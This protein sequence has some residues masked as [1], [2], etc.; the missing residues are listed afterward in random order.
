TDEMMGRQSMTPGYQAAAEW[1]AA[2]YEAWGLEPAGDNGT[3]FQRVPITRALTRYEGVPALGINGTAFSVI[4]GD[5]SINSVSTVATS[6]N[7]E[8]VFVGYGISAPAKGLDEYDG[9]NVRG[10][11]ALV[12]TGSPKDAPQS[13]GGG[14]MAPG[15][16][17]DPE[18]EEEWVEEST[19]PAKIQTAYD[20]GAAAVLLYNPDAA[21]QA[22]SG[23]RAPR[24][25]QGTLSPTRDFLAF[26]VTDR[27][28]RAIMKPDPQESVRGFTTRLNAVRNEI[29]YGTPQSVATGATA[30]LRGYASKEEYN[31]ELGNNFAYNVVAKLPGTDRGLRDEFVVMGGHLDHLGVR[32]GQVYNG[33]DD[34]A[35]GTAVAMEVA[36]VLSEGNH[37]PRRTIVFAAWCGEEMGLI[38]SGY[39]VSNPP[40]GIDI[41]KVVTYFNMDMVGL[42]NAIGA[43]GALNF[44]TIWDVIRRDQ[45]E[46]VIAAV[47][48]RTGGPGGSDHSA[49]IRLGIEALALMTSGGVGHPYYH[50]PEDDTEKIDAEILRKTGQFVLQGTINLAEER[51]VELLIEDRE[52]LYNAAQ[53]SLSSFNPGQG[54]YEKVQI[55]ARNR[56]ELVQ[57]VM[58][59]ALAVN[60]RLRQPAQ[61]AAQAGGRGGAATRGNKT[62][63]RGIGDLAVF[64]G[65]ANLLLSAAE[66]IGFGRLDIEGD[67]GSWFSGGHITRAGREAVG[68][69]EENNIWIHL[70]S[71]SESLFNE[72]L[73]LSS[74]PFIVTGEYTISASMVDA[75]NE[76]GVILGI[77]MDPS[78]VNGAITNL[79]GMKLRLGDTDNLVLSVTTEEGMDEAERALYMG[80]IE[81]GWEHLEIVGD[82]RA[83][84]GVAG[85]SLRVFST[86][87]AGMPMR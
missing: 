58:D 71:P 44:P 6:V 81:R 14:S 46:D 23:M 15:A 37:R 19:A 48:P 16:R 49:F 57:V 62:F 78:D 55:D 42:G 72:M 85:A 29:K 31:E 84:G 34:N 50:R 75:I 2:Q 20:K 53:F 13:G 76:K 77:T 33:A 51:E 86:S 52:T 87:G 61:A 17:T 26:S 67:D 56:A 30:D 22:A 32:D 82:R 68:I 43:P 7:A 70:A 18:P 21:A 54:N 35:S 41:D 83:G 11:V 9:V 8:I 4:E 59:S 25:Q 69:L 36:R 10:R 45:D 40:E 5:F 1:V 60:N 64:E 74:K 47:R 66:F 63:N 38:G 65:D 28:F 27:A 73:A 3:Y 39:F 79:E 12:L 24:G 80:L